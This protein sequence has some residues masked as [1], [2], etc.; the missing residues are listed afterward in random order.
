MGTSIRGRCQLTLKIG[1]GLR[2]DVVNLTIDF[3]KI[4]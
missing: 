3:K 1:G 2:I 4:K